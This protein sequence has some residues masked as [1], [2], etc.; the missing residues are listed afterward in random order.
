MVSELVPEFGVGRWLSEWHC[1]SVNVLEC[2][3]RSGKSA[4]T[5][6]VNGH[7]REAVNWYGSG[8]WE[9]MCISPNVF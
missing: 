8:R 9:G 7:I 2:T 6:E 4:R 5:W 3:M 1:C